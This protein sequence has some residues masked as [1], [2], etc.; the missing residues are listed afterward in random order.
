M[1]HQAK[2]DEQAGDSEAAYENFFRSGWDMGV[3]RLSEYQNI[4][5]SLARCS[6]TS[7][8]IARAKVAQVHL[9]CLQQRTGG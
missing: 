1:C 7:G 2:E 6:S 3:S 4:L 9:D 5:A 8:W